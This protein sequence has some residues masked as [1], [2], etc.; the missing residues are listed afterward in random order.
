[1]RRR[2]RETSI[3]RWCD[4]NQSDARHSDQRSSMGW[5]P[6]NC[7]GARAESTEGGGKVFHS[8][9]WHGTPL[10]GLRDAATKFL[11]FKALLVSQHPFKAL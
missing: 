9:S 3:S 4:A 5:A 2:G 1:M 8:L 7:P 11:L 6:D 10:A